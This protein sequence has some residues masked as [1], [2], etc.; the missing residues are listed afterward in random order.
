MGSECQDIFAKLKQAL[1]S[2]QVL[3]MPSGQGDYVLYTDASKLGL[4][5]VLM[6]ND[7]VIANASRHLKIHEINYP[8]HDLGLAASTDEQLQKWR[9]RD[10]ANGRKLYSELGDIVRYRDRLWVPHDD[11]LRDLIMKEAHDTPYSIHL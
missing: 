3:S 7:R 10:E 2:A 6:K 4:G 11:S 9:A 1:I 5:A 8:N